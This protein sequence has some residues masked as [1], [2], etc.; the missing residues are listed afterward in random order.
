MKVEIP[1]RR[2]L[3]GV[4]CALIRPRWW[5]ID[6]FPKVTFHYRIPKG[7][8]VGIWLE[9][10]NAQRATRD[11]DRMYMIGGSWASRSDAVGTI[12]WQELIDDDAW[13]EVTV[14]VRLIR[15]RLPDLRLLRGFHFAA[16]QMAK[17][18]QNFWF[19]DFSIRPESNQSNP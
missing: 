1:Q 2:T 7:V 9:T 14:D 4:T 5:D 11:F 18:K 3:T 12:G 16:V 6:R 10:F 8:P 13:H 17:E 19:D 15:E